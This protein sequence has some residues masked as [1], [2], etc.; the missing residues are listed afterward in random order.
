MV[1]KHH[2]QRQG[3]PLVLGSVRIGELSRPGQLI[4]VLQK[5]EEV[6]GM[7]SATIIACLEVASTELSIRT[8]LTI[9]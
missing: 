3:M 4:K 9:P 2:G 8:F 6:S 1:H 5:L 7:L